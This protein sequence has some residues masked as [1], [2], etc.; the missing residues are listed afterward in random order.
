MNNKN[1]MNECP[2]CSNPFFC[3]HKRDF[4]CPYCALEQL[5]AQLAERDALLKVKDHDYEVEAERCD[6]LEVALEDAETKLTAIAK[7]P[8]YRIRPRSEKYPDGQ[9]WESAETGEWLHESDLQAITGADDA[10]D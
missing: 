8:R 3:E 7:M 5:Q 9:W 6:L 10:C 2:T 4:R 1:Y